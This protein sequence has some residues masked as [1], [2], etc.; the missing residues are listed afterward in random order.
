MARVVDRV[1]R[2]PLLLDLRRRVLERAEALLLGMS[3]LL[4]VVAGAEVEV[5]VAVQGE[6]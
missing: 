2:D 6:V 3:P 5:R 4:L 1:R